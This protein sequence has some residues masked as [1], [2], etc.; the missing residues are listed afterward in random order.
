VSEAQPPAEPPEEPGQPAQ[1]DPAPGQPAEP[2]GA[3]GPWGDPAQQNQWAPPPYQPT[4]PVEQPQSILNAVRLMWA[5][6]AISAIGILVAFTQTSEL[7]DQLRDAD[8]TLTADEL[9]TAVA[10][11]LTF[12]GIIGVIS[13]ALWLWMAA[14]NG[15]GK[16]WART[17]AT[18]LGGLNVVFTAL[19]FFGDQLTPLNVVFSIISIVLAV[20]ILWLLYR[21]ESNAYFD[22]KTRTAM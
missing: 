6:A 7:R 22:Y 5:G 21:P 14:T 16:A 10:V 9:D 4:T 20:S 17:V 13:V 3:A 2:P 15:Q 19:G 11:G 8:E 1:Q 12:V 18:V